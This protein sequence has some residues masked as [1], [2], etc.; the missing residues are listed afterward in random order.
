MNFVYVTKC[1]LKGLLVGVLGT[2]LLFGCSSGGSEATSPNT[3]SSNA[4]SSS[5]SS[6][7]SSTSSSNA[8]S[9]SNSNSSSSTGS[10]SGG[11]PNLSQGSELYQEHGCAQ[12]H[13]VMGS[14]GTS[15]ITL[16]PENWNLQTLTGKIRDTMPQGS[17][18][19]CDQMCAESVA[20]YVLS[21]RVEKIC[22]GEEGILP[23]RLRLLTPHEYQLTIKELFDLS[24][25]NTYTSILPKTESIRGYDNNVPEIQVTY[26]HATQYWNL[27]EILSESVRPHQVV[28]CNDLSQQDCVTLMLDEFGQKVFRRPLYSEEKTIYTTLFNAETSNE[29]GMRQVL[30][31][32]L[33]SPNFLYR[34]E[35][36]EADGKGGFRLTSYEIASLL[37][38]TFWGSLPDEELF[39]LAA[40]NALINTDVL[41]AQ[42]QRLLQD[43]KAEDQLVYFARQWLGTK[44]MTDIYR[45]PNVFTHYN[46]NVGQAMAEEFH[47]FF[48]DAFLNKSS[49]FKDVF[50]AD[51]VYANNVLAS[52]YGLGGVSSSAFKKI[53][54]GAE[55]GG[56]L[57]L[58][59][60]LAVHA[61]MN[62]TS[63]IA[64]G[65]F[66]RERLMCQ[67]FPPP[68]PNAGGIIPLDPSLSTRVRFSA[69]TNNDGCRSCH[70][71]IDSIGFSFERYDGS[72]HYRE[73]EGDGISVD[74]SGSLTGLMLMSDTDYHAYTGTHGLAEVLAKSSNSAYCF[75]D[76]FHSYLHGVKQPDSC[77]VQHVVSRWSQKE[78]TLY[79]LWIESVKSPS[80]IQRQ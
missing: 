53:D 21:W 52:F 69:H 44:D 2:S 12:C 60:L 29:A 54:A 56:L 6:S 8:S 10:S 19:S 50:I 33:L 38:Y 35:L 36:G 39:S 41:L 1:Y 3:S 5:N 79:D 31:S 25:N 70:E 61:K 7:S 27:A 66:V 42:T 18:A 67:E 55:R 57:N 28:N 32:M 15:G 78:Y 4:S 76:Q 71:K 51:Y 43:P 62:Q 37:S 23:R 49:K 74:D 80:F 11:E 64:R 48:S 40:D 14:S 45:D 9:S 72:G 30:K 24:R 13:G 47:L 77:T 58:G 20:S 46:W 16:I 34:S 75:A 73:V 68:P 59:G 22:N 63:P 26:A 17:P 65:V